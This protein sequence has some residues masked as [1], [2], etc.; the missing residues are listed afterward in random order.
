[1]KDGYGN[2]KEKVAYTNMCTF[3]QIL[4]SGGRIVRNTQNRIAKS[5]IYVIIIQEKG[6]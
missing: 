5:S 6:L 3:T 1:M 2:K 4:G